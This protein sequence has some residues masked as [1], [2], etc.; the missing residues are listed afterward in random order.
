MNSLPT[1]AIFGV[2][3]A[4]VAAVAVAA[5]GALPVVSGSI[6]ALA[7]VIAAAVA[8][9]TQSGRLREDRSLVY[10]PVY[11]RRHDVQRRVRSDD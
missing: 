5:P 4:V 6:A 7:V 9:A 2:G 8:M 1:R 3:T 11:V 10:R